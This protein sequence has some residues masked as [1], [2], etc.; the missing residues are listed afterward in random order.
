MELSGVVTGRA[1]A[2]ARV[3]AQREGGRYQGQLIGGEERGAAR[4]DNGQTMARARGGASWSGAAS[5]AAARRDVGTVMTEVRRRG[6]Q[7]REISS[8]LAYT[9]KRGR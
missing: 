1:R 8:L 3:G 6:N 7:S 5:A 2:R 9:C 4:R